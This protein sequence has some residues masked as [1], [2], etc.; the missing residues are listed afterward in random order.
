MTLRPYPGSAVLYRCVETGTV[1]SLPAIRER[2]QG[3]I[4][5]VDDLADFAEELRRVPTAALQGEDGF[6]MALKNMVKKWATAD[7]KNPAALM[8]DAEIAKYLGEGQGQEQMDDQR[9]IADRIED[10]KRRQRERFQAIFYSPFQ[11]RLFGALLRL[12]GAHPAPSTLEISQA[13]ANALATYHPLALAW[14]TP[15]VVAKMPGAIRAVRLTSTG[16][17]VRFLIAAL[18]RANFI[19]EIHFASFCRAPWVDL[20]R[21][22]VLWEVH[23][24]PLVNR[25]QLGPGAV[26]DQNADVLALSWEAW[27]A[28]LTLLEDATI[29]GLVGAQREAVA[30]ISG[31]AVPAAEETKMSTSGNGT[32]S[33]IG[34]GDGTKP[35]TSARMRKTLREQGH[36]LAGAAAEGMA[37]GAVNQVGEMLITMTRVLIK[38][39]AGEH[40]AID[41]FLASPR[42]R[43][44]VKAIS[45]VLLHT[46]ACEFPNQ[47][48]AADGVAA[49]ARLQMKLSFANVSTEAL[50][51]I[52]PML[53]KMGE[54]GSKLPRET[55]Q[56]PEGGPLHTI[57]RELARVTET[58]PMEVGFA[59]RP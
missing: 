17:W 47:V 27:S 37:M 10:V 54:I 58:V 4:R 26:A 38:D 44:V 55:Q 57:E 3:L 13:T 31:P 6:N 16:P 15:H 41:A 24:G 50:E 22:G 35:V 52:G 7:V 36:L 32:T 28:L 12:D 53:A 34:V 51:K 5:T 11:P 8:T 42:G 45:A 48:P 14:Y 39:I 2:S 29:A 25:L 20:S 23:L 43:E 21:E 46:V 1:L 40:P 18:H 30:Q 33:T 49:A 9:S 56:L 19:D 59:A